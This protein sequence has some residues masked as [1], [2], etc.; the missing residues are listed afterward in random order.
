MPKRAIERIDELEE[1]LDRVPVGILALCRGYEPYQ[2]PV[3]YVYMRGRIY[4]HCGLKGR[5]LELL[6]Q[7]P[8][9]HFVAFEADPVT[10]SEDPCR[11]TQHYRSVMVSGTARLISTDEAK[12]EALS[13]LVA[14]YAAGEA[15]KPLPAGAE[16]GVSI[17]E[18]SPVSITGKENYPWGARPV[19]DS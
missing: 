12:R 1:V 3:N 6:R 4:I 10:V 13:A 15:V 8:Q 18:V 7:N 5:K 11:F 14:K 17:I 9:V 16:A 19:W 2:V